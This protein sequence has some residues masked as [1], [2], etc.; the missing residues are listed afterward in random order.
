MTA[1][2]RDTTLMRRM[3]ALEKIYARIDLEHASFRRSAAE[4][5]KAVAC[6]TRCG[7]CCVHF[8]PD[9]MPIEADR[10]A[11]FLLT[12]RPAMIDR[13]FARREDAYARDAACPFWDESKPGENCGVYPGRALICRL[14]GFSS[15]LNKVGEP[16]YALCHS[17]PPVPGEE[18]R[19]FTGAARMA[20]LFGAVPPPMADF[21]GEIVALDPDEAGRRASILDALPSALSRV[22][23]VLRLGAEE[24]V[25]DADRSGADALAAG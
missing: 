1:N 18:A 17:M 23:L 5:G 22:A 6:P 11:L 25:P 21:S 7:N 8:V 4:H 16:A 14:F 20:E 2:R 12:E 10:L 13:F 15:V 24:T 9:V 3:D 19:H